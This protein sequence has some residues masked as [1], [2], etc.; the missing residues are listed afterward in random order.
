M[1]PQEIELFQGA[2]QINVTNYGEAIP[3]PDVRELTKEFK[4]NFGTAKFSCKLDASVV[5]SR[6]SL[7]GKPISLTFIGGIAEFGPTTGPAE[8]LII[9][10]PAMSLGALQG[11]KQAVMMLFSALRLR[12]SGA[13]SPENFEEIRRRMSEQ[14]KE[15]PEGSDPKKMVN[16][17]IREIE[18]RDRRNPPSSP[19]PQT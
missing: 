14:M 17:L 12:Q 11:A 18:E 6:V 1:T 2:V 9:M 4:M 15:A 3:R 10:P 13:F 5:I 19:P 7:P 8:A 16:D